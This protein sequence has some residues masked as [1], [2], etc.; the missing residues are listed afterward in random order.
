MGY[1]SASSYI[2]AFKNNFGIS[3]ARYCSDK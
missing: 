1:S 2:Y 3:P